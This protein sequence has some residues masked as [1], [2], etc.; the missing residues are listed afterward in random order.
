MTANPR[1][2]IYARSATAPNRDCVATQLAACL[3]F[4][5]QQ[6]WDV[7]LTA[8]DEA[9]SGL[10]LERPG[11]SQ[12]LALIATDGVD[13]VLS[14]ASE[15]FARDADVLSSIVITCQNNGVRCQA[16]ANNL[17]DSLCV[18]PDTIADNHAFAPATFKL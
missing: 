16:L 1:V 10:E 12:I 11:L 2:A 8:T 7:V 6:G 15:R 4:C 17:S 13:I 9:I 18:E 3:L 5:Q 14:D